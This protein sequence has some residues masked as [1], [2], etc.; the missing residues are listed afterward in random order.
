MSK[1]IINE[2]YRGGNLD[3]GD[4]W[5][6]LIIVEDLTSSELESFFVG[7][8]TSSTDSKYSAYQ[9]TNMSGIAANFLKGTIVVVGGDGAITSE[10]TSYNPGSGDWD[11]LLRTTGTHLTKIAY[12]PPHNGDFA[13]TD[14]AY[15]DTSS[16]GD[17]ISADGFAVN[18][19][20]SPGTFGN[21]ANV[22][23]SAPANNIGVVLTS[24]LAGA[25]TGANWNTSVALGSMTLGDANGGD[26]TTFI[27]GVAGYNRSCPRCD[28]SIQPH[29][30]CHQCR[31]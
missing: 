24:D 14:V 7:D 25:A 16:T 5:V 30:Q 21:N 8:S 19:D 11:L 13:A 6:E 3:G 23:V 10:D 27:N 2:F 28:N 22:T 15:V 18:W 17:T 12:S 4:E 1:I 9:F 20:S 26:N 29:G 31:G